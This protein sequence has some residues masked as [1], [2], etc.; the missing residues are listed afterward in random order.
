MSEYQP[1]HVEE[2]KPLLSDGMYNRLKDLNQKVLPAAGALYSA[3]AIIW[4]FPKGVEVVG[5]IAAIGVFGAV[6]LAWASNRYEKSGV[7]YDGTLEV[8]HLDGRKVAVM[9]ITTQPE[10]MVNQKT[11][12]LKVS[13][14]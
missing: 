3:L 2:V 12:N 13:N 7:G 11:V 5:S 1:K 10:D 6:I 4:G 8:Q 14:V 9:D